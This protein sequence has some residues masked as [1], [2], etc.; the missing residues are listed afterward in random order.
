[1]QSLSGTKKMTDLLNF[2]IS[3]MKHNAV[4]LKEDAVAGIIRYTTSTGIF[5][6]YDVV[7]VCF[8]YKSSEFLTCG[9]NLTWTNQMGCLNKAPII[10][11]T[12]GDLMLIV[13]ITCS[14]QIG[15]EALYSRIS[16]SCFMAEC[17]KRWLNQ[18][19]FVLLCFA[20]FAYCEF[21]IYSVLFRLSVSVKWLAWRLPLKWPRLW[22]DGLWTPLYLQCLSLLTVQFDELLNSSDGKH[23]IGYLCT[24]IATE[25]CQCSRCVPAA[26]MSHWRCVIVV[27]IH[28]SWQTVLELIP[29][30]R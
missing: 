7:A 20:L 17:R 15:S 25:C 23:F 3:I 11:I 30:P 21:C 10:Y 14:P 16:P 12:V 1:M 19:S 13:C 24:M 26:I 6:I 8:V 5:C 27:D 28:V 18:G 22:W 9:R 2:V 29:R 4:Y